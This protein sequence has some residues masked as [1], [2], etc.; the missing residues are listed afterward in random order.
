SAGVSE[1]MIRLSI[2]IEHIDDLLADL[3]Q[4]LEAV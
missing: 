4:A 3:N 1:G 2:G